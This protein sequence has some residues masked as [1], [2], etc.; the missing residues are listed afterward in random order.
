M[1]HSALFSILV[2]FRSLVCAYATSERQQK[3]INTCWLDP[4]YTYHKCCS[5]ANNESRTSDGISCW[6]GGLSAKTCCTFYAADASVVPNLPCWHDGERAT[7][8]LTL[9][10]AGRTVRMLQWPSEPYVP[11]NVM[12]R[13]VWETS[14]AL[15]AWLQHSWKD[16]GLT[17][18][19]RAIEIGCGL[20]LPGIVA[21]SLGMDTT[22][23]DIDS[24]G[25]SLASASAAANLRPEA[26]ARFN[27]Q[28]IDFRNTESL[29]ELGRFD[30]L[31]VSGSLYDS[32]LT[33]PLRAAIY[34]L[35]KVGCS[36]FM[37]TEG[38]DQVTFHDILEFVRTLGVSFQ[39]VE[40]FMCSERGF[41]PPLAPPT[42]I[43]FQASFG[44]VFVTKA[45]SYLSL[46]AKS[47]SSLATSMREF[48]H[49]VLADEVSSQVVES[50]FK[51]QTRL[52]PNASAVRAHL[53]RTDALRC[54]EVRSNDYI[55]N[56]DACQANV[57]DGRKFVAPPCLPRTRSVRRQIRRLREEMWRA[58]QRVLRELAAH[59]SEVSGDPGDVAWLEDALAFGEA[60]NP[61]RTASERRERDLRQVLLRSL[62]YAPTSISFN[63]SVI[64]DDEIE[65]AGQRQW[66]YNSP[67][68]DATWLTL[69]LDHGKGLFTRSSASRRFT[70]VKGRGRLIV[71]PGTRLELASRGFYPASCH[72]I[73]LGAKA[74]GAV[75]AV[76]YSWVLL[77]T[78][79]CCDVL[80]EER[81]TSCDWT[82]PPSAISSLSGAG[83]DSEMCKDHD[84]RS[85]VIRAPE[86]HNRYLF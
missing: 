34:S 45:N 42:C 4:T 39:N 33:E 1:K 19:G 43:R 20:A 40:M 23:I 53:T 65:S 22:A 21:A 71:F 37:T 49:A 2:H 85:C 30:L 86:R 84:V 52:C 63:G 16:S 13:V 72:G 56:V 76:R 27:T 17:A 8:S 81:L 69:V 62:V 82:I 54:T 58:A 9:D 50:L 35:C 7:Y 15:A 18:G 51:L 26:L 66:S 55:L 32:S 24:V 46:A 75:S 48:G 74:D 80:R 70:E 41:V 78:S 57:Y 83:L 3:V 73:A 10:V 29:G 38:S 25:L 44:E 68:R 67:H 60:G 47:E 79:N 64:S 77:Y 12:S 5:C 59:Q 11:D 31:L 36:V 61:V 28:P 6:I 14:Y